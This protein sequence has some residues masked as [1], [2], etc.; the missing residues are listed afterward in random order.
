M[1]RQPLR[2]P[3]DGEAQVLGSGADLKCWHLQGQAYPRCHFFSTF[4]ANKLYKDTGYNYDQVRF[5]E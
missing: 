3:G 2:P 5:F 1:P 4:F